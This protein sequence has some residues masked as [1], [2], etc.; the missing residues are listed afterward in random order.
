[1]YS[2]TLVVYVVLYADDINTIDDKDMDFRLDFYLRHEWNV[3][4]HFCRP[5]LKKLNEGNIFL[6]TTENCYD[7]RKDRG[8][9]WR[10]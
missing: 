10:K 9:Y 2:Q 4:K 1:M 6:N 3:S 5:Y 7:K 8:K